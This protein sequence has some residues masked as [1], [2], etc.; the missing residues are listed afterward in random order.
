MQT[1]L[2]FLQT[3]LSDTYFDLIQHHAAILPRT[4]ESVLY[5]PLK[6]MYENSSCCFNDNFASQ[7]FRVFICHILLN[8]SLLLSNCGSNVR[9]VCLETGKLSYEEQRLDEHFACKLDDLE[10]TL[11]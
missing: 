1:E 7:I 11:F 10:L 6:H 5:F 3:L 8:L 4:T 9:E 2:A